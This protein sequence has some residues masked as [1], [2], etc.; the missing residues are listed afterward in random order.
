MSDRSSQPPHEHSEPTHL[1]LLSLFRNGKRLTQ[2]EMTERLPIDSKRQAR[3]LLEKLQAAGVPLEAHRK[4]RQKEYYLPP[5]E[6]ETHLHLDLT[7]QE[8]LALLLA[9]QAANAGLGPAPLENALRGA[10]EALVDGFP[11]SVTTFE[12]RS[13][14]RQVHFGDAASVEID[15]EGFTDLVA[16]LTNRRG[17][18]IDYY[19]ASSDRL[20]KGRRIDPL[21]LAVRGD[22]WICVAYDHKTGERRDFNL[23]RIEAV[24]PRRPDSNGG[25]YTIPEDFD[26][27]LYFID[28]FESLAGG[29]VHEVRLRVEPDVVPYFESK[30]YHR[31]QQI[32]KEAA[33]GDRAI[34]SYEVAGLEEIASF[35]RSWGT[36]VKVLAPEALA[37]RIAEEARRM[38]A[39]YDEDASAS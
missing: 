9:V 7:E 34:V 21:G 37:D 10:T 28:R 39:R 13:L 35:V 31:T 27:E 12:P 22:A 11:T 20:Y 18:A 6:W 25:D 23:T 5:E 4:G 26:L 14:M 8:A 3:R 17:I 32:H 36:T 1:Q 33:D 38:A 2:A 30:A 24:R 15:P 16:A 29:T 19:S